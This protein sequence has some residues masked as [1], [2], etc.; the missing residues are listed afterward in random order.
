MWKWR[1]SGT[2]CEGFRR[3]RLSEAMSILMA[4]AFEPS[5]RLLPA[6]QRTCFTLQRSNR[7][8]DESCPLDH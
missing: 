7:S 6:P 2:C 5:P 1:G 4:V 3:G 8:E